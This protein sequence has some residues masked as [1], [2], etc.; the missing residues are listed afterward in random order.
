MSNTVLLSDIADAARVHAMIDAVVEDGQDL[1]WT[2]IGPGGESIADATVWVEEARC[3]ILVWSQSNVADVSSPFVLLAKLAA[4]KEAAISVLIDSVSVPASIGQTTVYD[5]RGWRGQP[6]RWRKWFGGHLYM[7]D[8][9]IAAKYKVAGRDPPPANA[10]RKMLMRQLAVAVPAIFAAFAL[11]MT[12]LGYWDLLGMNDRPSAAEA[13]AWSKVDPK[14]C[15]QLRAFV[16]AHPKGALKAEAQ[17][18]IDGR[19]TRS[20][21]TWETVTRPMSSFYVGDGLAKGMPNENQARADLTRRMDAAASRQCQ[22]IAAAG[23]ALYIGF[24]L[25]D[26]TTICS[27]GGDGYRCTFEGGFDCQLNEPI[28]VEV[29]TCGGKVADLQ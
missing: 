26:G 11:P 25:Q 16:T 28:A 29:E 2:Q 27:N 18:L 14:D 6:G 21:Q 10:P 15:N 22:G 5:L 9:V 1:R 23:Q 24:K 7:R 19:I 13:K 12:L 8:L 17:A 3:V 20:E 4:R